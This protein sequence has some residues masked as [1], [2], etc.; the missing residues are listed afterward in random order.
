MTAFEELD[1]REW[2]I[3]GCFGAAGTGK[4]VLA[5]YLWKRWQGDR[6]AID[7]TYDWPTELSKVTH[8]ELE[9]WPVQEGYDEA[10]QR[11][12]L[13]YR[14]DT[15]Q[16]AWRDDMD[17]AIGAALTHARRTAR[18]TLVLCDEIGE[19]AINPM[20]TLPN[21]RRVLH[22]GRHYGVN[23]IGNGPRPVDIPKLFLQ[24]CRYVAMFRLPNPADRERI[25]D[26]MGFP[27][28]LIHQLHAE[29]P[30]FGF[31]WLDTRAAEAYVYDPIPIGKTKKQLRR[32]QGD[33][34][35][36][37]SATA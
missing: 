20:A 21:L 8:V 14:P 33:V 7:P 10:R 24:Q 35:E 28:E 11:Q 25:A 19:M 12:S 23:C 32:P 17:R 22:T 31:V 3:I 30:E 36:T 37:T 34:M 18:P 26:T 1:M 9:Q 15:G 16:G 2:W 13:I 29:T 4:S 6:L 27:R 5:N